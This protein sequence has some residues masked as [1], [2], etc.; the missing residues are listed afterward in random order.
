M[1]R[2]P[3][4]AALLA[5]FASL[6]GPPAAVAERG[7]DSAIVHE[8]FDQGATSDLAKKLLAH[9]HITLAKGAGPDG[10]DAIRVAYAGSDQGSERVV[11][12]Y[13]LGVAMNEATLSFDVRFDKDFQWT[14]GGKLHGLGPERPVTGGKPRRPDGWSARVVFKERGACATYL[15]DQSEDL[16]YGLQHTSKSPVFVPGEWR[17]V[18][19]QVKLNDAGEANGYA[20]ILIDGE[21]VIRSDDIQFR[22]QEGEETQIGQF[23]FSTFHGGSS[24]RWTPI[25]E[26]GTPTTVYAYFDNFV[27]TRGIQSTSLSGV[28]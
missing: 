21:E 6:S 16:K 27:V 1:K 19:L 15:Y 13:S 11:V 25:D 14:H 9:R 7:L 17:R 22:G 10:S 20:R 3:A 28:E 24:S 2:T 12:A 4:V 23:L 8:T 26:Q 5:L 18:V